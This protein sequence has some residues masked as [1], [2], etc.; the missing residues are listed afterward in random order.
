MRYHEALTSPLNA[1]ARPIKLTNTRLTVYVPDR[2]AV[3]FAQLS[4]SMN[5]AKHSPH[6][7][8][9]GVPSL[10]FAKHRAEDCL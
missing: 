4:P 10:L 6:I 9:S 2:A 1:S 3:T 8:F 5:V 7:Y